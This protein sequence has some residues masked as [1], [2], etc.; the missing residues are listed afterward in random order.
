MTIQMIN[1]RVYETFHIYM[2]IFFPSTARNT[3]FL[4][5]VVS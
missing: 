5:T 1:L 3:G 2:Y 4:G